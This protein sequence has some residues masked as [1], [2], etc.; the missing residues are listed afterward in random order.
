MSRFLKLHGL[1]LLVGL[2]GLPL[3]LGACWVILSELEASHQLEF[4]WL[5]HNLTRVLK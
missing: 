1:A 3:S 4:A 5:A 2:A